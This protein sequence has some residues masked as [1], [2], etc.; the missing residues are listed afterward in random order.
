MRRMPCATAARITLY[1]PRQF[2]RKASTG[3]G[4][5]TVQLTMASM[6]VARGQHL[7]VVGDVYDLRFVR[8]IEK[9][10]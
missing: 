7:V 8:G 5:L 3:C 10:R 6:P 9:D 1:A 4:R 2:T